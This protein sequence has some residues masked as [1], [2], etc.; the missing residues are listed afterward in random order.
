MLDV[1]G[2]SNR[3]FSSTH[4]F[5]LAVYTRKCV[6]AVGWTGNHRCNHHLPASVKMTVERNL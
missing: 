3:E 1:H 5:K 6:M 4:I 2:A